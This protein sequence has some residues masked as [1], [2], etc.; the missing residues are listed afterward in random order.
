MYD[1]KISYFVHIKYRIQFL[2]FK[3]HLCIKKYYFY[4][5]IKAVV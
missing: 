5:R 2:Y 3:I 1:H 4:T